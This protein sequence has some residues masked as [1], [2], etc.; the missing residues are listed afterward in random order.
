MKTDLDAL[1]A[2]RNLDAILVTGAGDHNPPMVYLAGQAH[3]TQAILVKKRGARPVLFYSPM[4]REEAAR[5]GLQTR[6]QEDYPFRELFKQAEGDPATAVALGYQRMLNDLG[7]TSGR[8][9]VCGQSDAGAAFAIFSALQR[10]MPGLALVGN[11]GSSVVDDA[12]LTKDQVEVERIRAMGK[13]TV[14]VVGQVADFLTSHK[15]KDEVLIQANGAPLTI[16]DV[17]SRINLWLAE[18]GAENPEGTIFAIGRDSAIPHSAGNPDDALRL[19]QTIVF[20]IFPCEAGG[21]YFYDFTRTWCLGYAPDEAQALYQD[22]LNVYN[23]V[24]SQLQMGV[25]CRHYQDLA[26]DL[27]EAGGH[28]SQKNSPLT[29]DG[30]VHGLGHGLG[31]HIHERPYFSLAYDNQDS[32]QPNLVMS[33]EPGLYYPDRGLGV[34]LED[35]LW[36]RPDGQAEVLADFPMDLI[37]PMK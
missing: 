29:Q 28:P 14:E 15:T 35:T 11:L 26:C 1:M 24:F 2:A 3:L 9:A 8:V 31:L 36:F 33:L 20:D 23:Q 27:F 25:S 21:G 16:R 13:M 6:N 17:K 18:R 19:G 5:S 4:E 30:Y 10:V 12:M 32:L 22:V 37:L 7:V 34:R